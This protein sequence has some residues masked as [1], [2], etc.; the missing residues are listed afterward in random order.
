MDVRMRHELSNVLERSVAFETAQ[1][2]AA[3]RLVLCKMPQ[4]RL[5]ARKR[6]VAQRTPVGIPGPA[7]YLTTWRQRAYVREFDSVPCPRVALYVVLQTK[8]RSDQL[9]LGG[10]DI[11]DEYTGAGSCSNS[12][13]GNETTFRWNFGLY[14][15]IENDW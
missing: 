8:T 5:A 13:Q 10:A 11:M 2:V 15:T 12:R 4:T 14:R 9:R 1:N 6:L 3:C 7:I